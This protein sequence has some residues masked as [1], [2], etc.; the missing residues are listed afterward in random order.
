MPYFTVE[1]VN[2]LNK[3]PLKI[4]RH[5]VCFASSKD[6]TFEPKFRLNTLLNLIIA[7]GIAAGAITTKW[8]LLQ[9][10]SQ[11]LKA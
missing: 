2:D 11:A 1:N 6:L 10:S 3:G 5:P 8:T 4:F 9:L 7:T